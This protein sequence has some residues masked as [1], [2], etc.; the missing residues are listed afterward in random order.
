MV[1]R[2]LTS[3]LIS[4]FP[5]CPFLSMPLS[6][7]VPHLHQLTAVNDKMAEYTNAPGTASLNAALMHTLQRHRDILQVCFS[8]LFLISFLWFSCFWLVFCGTTVLWNRESSYF[9]MHTPASVFIFLLVCEAF[10]YLLN[11]FLRRITHTSSTKLKATSWP[12]G[13]GKTCSGPSEKTSSEYPLTPPLITV[14]ALSDFISDHKFI[15]V[16]RGRRRDLNHS[17]TAFT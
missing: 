13:K 16:Y 9:M 14:L 4:W 15:F 17:W 6:N 2:S 5:W 12:S 8:L 11:L 1:C 7:H 10:S 3:P